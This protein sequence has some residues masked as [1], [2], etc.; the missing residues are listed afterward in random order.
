[1]RPSWTLAIRSGR[2][3]RRSACAAF[4]CSS[5]MPFLIMSWMRSRMI[6]TMSRYS[7]TSASSAMRPWPGITIVPPSCQSLGIGQV[8]DAVQ[9]AI[10]PLKRA[11]ALRVD[12]RIA[13]R[14]EDVAGDDDVGAAEE[15][16]AV[17]VGVR[18]R[19]VKQLDRL[20]VDEDVL[21]FAGDRCRSARR[22]RGIGDGLP[23]GALIGVQH[24][25][26]ARSPIAPGRRRPPPTSAA[27]DACCRPSRAPR[28][29]RCD[30]D[31]RAC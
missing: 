28:C 24:R 17:A 7:T 15:H 30:P 29:R 8:D 14:S 11:A 27:A 13:G 5:V 2:R 21:R 3:S 1:M 23:V 19:L 26:R 22:R 6:V 18:G 31:A 10:T 16:D 4:T 9:R 25:S 12:D 20:A